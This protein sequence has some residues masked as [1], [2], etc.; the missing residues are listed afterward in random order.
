MIFPVYLEKDTQQLLLLQ[1]GL[2]KEKKNKTLQHQTELG[3]AL[4]GLTIKMTLL[5]RKI[6][7]LQLATKI[8]EL[9]E[10]DFC[11]EA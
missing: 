1:Q 3:G 7:A 6:E 9:L 11:Q 8:C 4:S 10:Q 5:T 2:S